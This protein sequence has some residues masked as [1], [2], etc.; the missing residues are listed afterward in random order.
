MTDLALP[1]ILTVGAVWLIGLTALAVFTLK[2]TLM[3]G[4]VVKD[5]LP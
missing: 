3:T 1:I 5:L 2:L 4:Q